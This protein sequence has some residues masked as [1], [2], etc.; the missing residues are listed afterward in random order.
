MNLFKPNLL[1]DDVLPVLQ[2]RHQLA[3]LVHLESQSPL[4]H[5]LAQLRGP[6]SPVFGL[7]LFEY[8][9]NGKGK[10]GNGFAEDFPVREKS[11]NQALGR[12]IQWRVGIVFGNP[13]RNLV[14][15]RN[16]L[17]KSLLGQ[18]KRGIVP[19]IAALRACSGLAGDSSATLGAKNQLHKPSS[20]VSFELPVLKF[21]P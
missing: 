4:A 19:K 16:N 18:R 13:S 14:F 6:L 12:A 10:L 17:P 11:R 7:G 21:A 9:L 5:E 3:L 8:S 15:G 1:A 20:L 2:D